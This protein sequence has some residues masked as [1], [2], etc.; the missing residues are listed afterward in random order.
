M[1]HVKEELQEIQKT[2]EEIKREK[3]QRKQIIRAKLDPKIVNYLTKKT[4]LA[5]ATIKKNISLLR[6][7]YPSCTPNAV[8]QIFAR[9]RGST[10]MRQLSQKD[11]NTLPHMEVSRQ[12]ITINQK[13]RPKKEDIKDMIIYETDDYF[14][15]GHIKEINRAYTKGCYTSVHILARKIIENLIR[16]ILIKKFPPTTKN[17]KELYFNMAQ[18]RFK[19]FSVILKNLYDKRN[20]FELHKIKVIERLYQKGKMFKDDAN[21]ATHSWYYLIESKKEIDELNIQ[22]IIELIKKLEN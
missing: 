13:Q 6:A 15:K 19:D 16:E 9:S 12:K 10:V 11:K 20:D 14:K 22:A 2:L 4:G 17:N 8:A 7:D 3:R 21:D 1:P 5:E 18:N